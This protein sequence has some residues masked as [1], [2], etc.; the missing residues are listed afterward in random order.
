LFPLIA[1]VGKK[2]WSKTAPQFEERER[3]RET[4]FVIVREREREIEVDSFSFFC[5]T[6]EGEAH[7][8]AATP[9]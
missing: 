4:L 7:L 1:V 5:A 8:A 9:E 3:E 2:Y 6:K